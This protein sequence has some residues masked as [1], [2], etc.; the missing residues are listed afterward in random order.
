MRLL[1]PSD[2][3]CSRKAEEPYVEEFDAAVAAGL[4][5]SLFSF[6]DFQA[7]SFGCKPAAMEGEKVVYRGWMLSAAQYHSLFDLLSE[8][9]MKLVTSPAQYQLCHYL[10]GWLEALVAHTPETLVFNETDDVESLLRT[11]GWQEC[12]LKDYVKSLSTEGGSLVR[13]LTQ[14]PSVISRM[15]K[16]RGTI[17]GG[18]CAR[19]VEDFVPGTE[20]RHFVVHGEPFSH[21]GEVPEIVKTAAARIDSPF[22]SVDIVRRT[23]GVWRIV[24]LGD[25]QVSDRKAWPADQFMDMVRQLERKT[26]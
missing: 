21:E 2:P 9:G 13:D 8:Q 18:L 19:R 26:I 7:G 22:F 1:F 14:I 5:V 11:A 23:D 15:R 10:P 20:E 4:P 12:F 6:E 24:E 17:E 25:G 16:Y 3:F